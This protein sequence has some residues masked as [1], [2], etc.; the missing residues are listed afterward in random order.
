[1]RCGTAPAEDTWGS[2]DIGT[3]MTLSCSCC[4][5]LPPDT[6]ICFYFCFTY[7]CVPCGNDCFHPRYVISVPPKKNLKEKKPQSPMQSHAAG[8][9]FSANAEK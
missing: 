1:M 8:T 7:V 9:I 4:W 5:N 6:Q 2:F 3:T